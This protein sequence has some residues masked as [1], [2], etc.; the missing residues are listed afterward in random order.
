MVKNLQ[1]LI[2]KLGYIQLD[3]KHQLKDTIVNMQIQ[4]ELC[5][6]IIKSTDLIS[7]HKYWVHVMGQ[8]SQGV[9]CMILQVKRLKKR[10]KKYTI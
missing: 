9:I 4:T 2:E 8:Y 7:L 5:A 6:S 1:N 10:H 3:K